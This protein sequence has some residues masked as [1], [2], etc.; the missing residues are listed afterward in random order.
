MA[1]VECC[2]GVIESY[3]TGHTHTYGHIIIP[4][5]DSLYLKYD[6]NDYW[7][8][9][10]KVAFVSPNV[11]HRIICTEKIVYFNI[12]SEMIRESDMMI[13][14]LNPVFEVYAEL[15]PLLRIIHSEA[16]RNVGSDDVRY[17]FYY[18]YSKMVSRNKF[19]SIRYIEDHYSVQIDISDLAALEEYSTAYYSIWFKQRMG[20]SPQGYIKSFRIE[21]AKEFLINTTY[22][23]SKIAYQVGYTDASSFARAFKASVGKTP[24]Q[25]RTENRYVNEYSKLPYW[26]D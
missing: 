18:L 6:K 11:F 1:L 9:T 10:K 21:K 14:H 24:Q 15:E 8:D 23:V 4:L 25:Y 17:L 5:S 12:P 22:R 13:L 26:E 3:M 7:L 2:C 16:E 19:K 20:L